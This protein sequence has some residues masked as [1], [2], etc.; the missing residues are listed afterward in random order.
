MGV[1][2]KRPSISILAGNKEGKQVN[3]FALLMLPCLL[4]SKV[5][6]GALLNF[7]RHLVPCVAVPKWPWDKD[8]NR[9]ESSEV[10]QII[11]HRSTLGH[12]GSHIPVLGGHSHY[13]LNL[14]WFI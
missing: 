14:P 11:L 2:K 8:S 3:C 6:E 10:V 4:C 12:R 13:S 5:D 7:K 1:L 9:A